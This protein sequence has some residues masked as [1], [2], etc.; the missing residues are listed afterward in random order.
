MLENYTTYEDIFAGPDS[1]YFLRL[2]RDGSVLTGSWSPDGVTWTQGWSRDLG[3]QLDDLQQR[4]VV[5]GLSWFNSAN[6]YADYDYI[7][8]QPL[9]EPP[10]CAQ[11]Y[12]SVATLWPP[13]HQFAP[14]DV[15]GVT[16][17][18]G[19]PISITI[20]SIFQD[21]PVDTTGDGR[22]V[23][24]GRGVGT[25][26]AQVRAERAGTKQAPG[27]GRVYHIGFSAAD[28]QGGACSGQVLVSV[29]HDQS[30]PAVDGG[31]QFDS[32]QLPILIE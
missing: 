3:S 17:P 26:T 9:N 6:S 23:P 13:N 5:T 22:F 24:D 30:G 29:P 25:S 15:M 16:D 19:D 32:T 20:D 4:V 31:A 27:D 14:I 11:A 18:D 21:E 12:P 28:G 10:I 1:T 8:L 7:R 2:E